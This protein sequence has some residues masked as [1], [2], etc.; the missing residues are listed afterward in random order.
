MKRRRYAESDEKSGRDVKIV[1]F[2]NTVVKASKR[3]GIK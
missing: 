3:Y 2:L 1:G